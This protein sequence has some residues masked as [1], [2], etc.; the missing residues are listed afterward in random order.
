MR[1]SKAGYF[2]ANSTLTGLP[3]AE[4]DEIVR[5]SDAL[6]LLRGETLWAPGD[7]PDSIYWMRSGV[8]RVGS[9]G[10]GQ[11]ELTLRFHGRN[12]VFGIRSLFVSGVRTTTALAHEDALVF[13][14]PVT[15]MEGAARRH[16]ELGLRLSGLLVERQLRLEARL[17]GLIFSPVQKRLL[18]IFRELGVDFGV[19]D[20]RGI[21][22]TLRL[23]QRELGTLVGA[24]RETV[25]LAM[26]ALRKAK[27]VTTEDRRIVL[28]GEKLRKS[29]RRG[30]TPRAGV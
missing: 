25:S 24:S 19:R 22:L 8:V 11:R 15:V 26:S 23:T 27:A 2:R 4:L 1:R 3:A 13:R 30:R 28:L 12:E 20:S 17:S 14:T 6:R 9:V 18:A 7:A 29:P 5:A 16:G 21:I 10:A